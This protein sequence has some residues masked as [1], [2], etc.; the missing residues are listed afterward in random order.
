MGVFE[1]GNRL[2]IS[3]KDAGGKWRNASTGHRIGEEEAAQRKLDAVLAMVASHQPKPASARLNSFRAYVAA[4]LE[5][6]RE[7]GHDWKADRGRLNKHVLPILGDVELSE[8]RPHHVADLVHRLRFKSEPKLAPRTV[9]NI[10][11]V[12]AAL[13]RDA[14]IEGLIETTPCILTDAQLGSI[15]DADPEWR[16]GAVFTREEAEALISDERI[17][18]DRQMVYA[19]GLLAGLRPGEAS[20]L[21]W[22][23]YEPT[24]QPLG[25]LTI[26]KSFNTRRNLLKS[27][28]TEAV[29]IIP[30]HPVLAAML[31]AWKLSGWFAMMGRRPE[32]DD[33]IVP[34][35]PD[36]A[37]RTK[38]PGEAFRGTNYSYRRWVDI[39]LP[40]L[41][42]RD[43][44][45]YD[46]RATFITLA[47][48]EDGADREVIRTRVTHTKSKRDAFDG[49]ARG[50]RWIETCT[51]IAKLKIGR[52]EAIAMAV[53]AEPPQCNL[54]AVGTSDEK[55]TDTCSGGGF[56]SGTLTAI[57]ST[58]HDGTSTL[59]H[60]RAEP[61]AIRVAL[62]AISSAWR[63][64]PGRTRREVLR[65]L[66]ALD[67]GG[68]EP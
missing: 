54:S 8:L 27:T 37:A 53:G 36:T 65:L 20:A 6:R 10:Y 41:G 60:E 48:D 5:R 39:D 2:W 34:L 4:W 12:I 44:S 1:R 7:A 9:R 30:V 50:T 31:A 64:E 22:R 49:Y 66:A 47:C 15:V 16:A 58:K 14:A 67:G 43:R 63:S 57:P 56:R 23:N 55:N 28:K 42:W 26:A 59:V 3:F 40:M 62:D 25:R 11:T 29:K 38:R 32:P 61:D 24:V 21:R 68:D 13:C 45:V 18:F 52:R 17:P 35:P 19:F 46:T 33:L 51:E